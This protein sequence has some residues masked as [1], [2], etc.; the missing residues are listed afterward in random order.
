MR[1]VSLAAGAA[2]CI[3]RAPAESDHRV[4]PAA[5]PRDLTCGFCG[6]PDLLPVA[7]GLRY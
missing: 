7:A 6:L 3:N 4:A 2:R 1:P 5:R